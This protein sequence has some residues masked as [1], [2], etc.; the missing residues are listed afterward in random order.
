MGATCADGT[1]DVGNIAGGASL[2]S[3]GTADSV[4]VLPR[5]PAAGS[6]GLA[7]RSD[8]VAGAAPAAGRLSFC[9]SPVK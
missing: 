1:P 6:T 7:A 4:A 3:T 9:E 5:G 8:G 2:A